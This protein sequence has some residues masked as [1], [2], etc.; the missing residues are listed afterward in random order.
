V[1]RNAA[2]VL[3]RL[4]VAIRYAGV[5]AERDDADAALAAHEFQDEGRRYANLLHEAA[6]EGGRSAAAWGMPSVKQWADWCS[7]VDRRMLPNL[8][9]LDLQW[10]KWWT[11]QG[12]PPADLQKFERLLGQ[13]GLTPPAPGQP[14]LLPEGASSSR[15][16]DPGHPG[17]IR[18]WDA[19]V[20]WGYNR[21]PLDFD[22]GESHPE[23]SD[24]STRE[25]SARMARE[26]QT[27]PPEKR[28]QLRRQRAESVEQK[29]RE[30][31][32]TE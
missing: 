14:P 29:T 30:L 11:D 17:S 2:G 31:G 5:L 4:P 13:R 26:N 20:G 27:L 1:A 22:L 19:G 21:E 9:K 10:V 12:R 15:Y 3:A 28:E 24:P 16:P 8:Q 18:W 6:H 32:V 25:F 7:T 23:L